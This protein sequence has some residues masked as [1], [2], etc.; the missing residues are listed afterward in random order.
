METIKNNIT[1]LVFM[2]DATGFFN[3]VFRFTERDVWLRQVMF[4]YASDV[5]FARDKEH[6]TSLCGRAAKQHRERSKRFH[7]CRN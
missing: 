5:R 4:A 3:D 1:E 2:Q 6:I 7:S